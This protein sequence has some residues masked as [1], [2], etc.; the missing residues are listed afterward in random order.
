[1]VTHVNGSNLVGSLITATQVNSL[2]RHGLL[3]MHG[4]PISLQSCWCAVIMW[5]M[6]HEPS[7]LVPGCAH[8]LH[9][10]V[11]RGFLKSYQ[12]ECPS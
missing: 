6:M 1:M 12:S 8:S 3:D 4:N 11:G 10:E 9:R 5:Q 2:G 7:L